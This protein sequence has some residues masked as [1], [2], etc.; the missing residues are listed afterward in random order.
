QLIHSRALRESVRVLTAAV[1]H[2]QKRHAVAPADCGRDI[3]EVIA[4]SVQSP[5]AQRVREASGDPTRSQR[6]TERSPGRQSRQ[7]LAQLCKK[8]HHSFKS[9][10]PTTCRLVRMIQNCRKLSK[11]LTRGQREV[12]WREEVFPKHSVS[13]AQRPLS[14]P[15]DATMKAP[16]GRPSARSISSLNCDSH[17]RVTRGP[18][19]GQLIKGELVAICELFQHRRA[20]VK[21][22][23]SREAVVLRCRSCASGRRPIAT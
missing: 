8:L 14:R 5:G 20:Y 3:Q 6:G 13:S 1:Q 18:V 16:R 21:W 7:R 9:C 22:H 4:L 19:V 2:N 15:S 10:G 12:A 17:S 11:A 23:R